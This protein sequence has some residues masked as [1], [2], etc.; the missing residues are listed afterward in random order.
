MMGYRG[1]LARGTKATACFGH[2]L[3]YTSFE[4]S[5]L[6]VTEQAL[7]A[8]TAACSVD[9]SISVTNTGERQGEE[10]IQIYVQAPLET[11]LPR[12]LR[13][14]AAFKKVCLKAA[15][16]KSFSLRIGRSEFSYWDPAA[17]FQDKDRGAWRVDTG[18]YTFH[19][20]NSLDNIFC[21]KTV[22]IN[23]G[24]CWRGL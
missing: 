3:S 14:L 9:L 4:M 13:A 18:H 8:D 5:N 12:P 21:S 11:P 1:L 19:A 10:V 15:E 22:Y 2:G 7:D 16:T 24:F 20:G 6:Q 17:E 23:R